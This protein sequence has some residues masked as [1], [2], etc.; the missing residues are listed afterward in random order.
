M[1]KYQNYSRVLFFIT[2]VAIVVLSV[3]PHPHS[4]ITAQT[5]TNIKDQLIGLGNVAYVGE[6]IVGEF[7]DKYRHFLAFWTL[8]ILLDLAYGFK[9]IYKMVF[10]LV[11]G[12]SIEVLQFFVPYREFDLYDILFN[13]IFILL[14]FLFSR[15]LFYFLDKR[16]SVV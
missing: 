13:I 3:T 15:F 10:L 11:Y 1:I 12:T 9:T 5:S 7:S 2:L 8:A 14:C 6:E 4:E 16:S